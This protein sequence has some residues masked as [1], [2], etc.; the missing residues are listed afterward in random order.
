MSEEQIAQGA[1]FDKAGELLEGFIDKEEILLAIEE[2]ERLGTALKK[3]LPAKV[4][5]AHRP[6]M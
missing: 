2:K 1:V 5:I 6:V 3:S 4:G